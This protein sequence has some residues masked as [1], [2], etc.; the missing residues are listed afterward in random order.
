MATYEEMLTKTAKEVQ[1]EA[2]KMIEEA[3]GVTF[4]RLLELAKADRD[5]RIL[6]VTDD[7]AAAMHA[8]AFVL[9]DDDLAGAGL[10]WRPRGRKGAPLYIS[11]YKASDL[12]NAAAMAAIT[13]EVVGDK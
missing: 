6:V 13:G 5:G 2:F 4:D 8:G 10:K 7:M 12:L 9:R 3:S 11:Y 1:E